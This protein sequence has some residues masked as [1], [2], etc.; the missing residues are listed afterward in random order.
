MTL[1]A[2]AKINIGLRVLHKRD[3]GFHEIETVFHRIALVDEIRFEASEGIGLKVEGSDLPTDQRNLCVRAALALK[4][5]SGVGEGVSIYLKKSIPAGAGLGGGSSDAATTLIGLRRLW[6][7]LIDDA[8]LHRLAMELGSDVPY[9]L[10]R[11]AAYA[12]GRGEL[13]EDLPLEVPY[14]IVV[15]HPRVHVSTQAAYR[16][17]AASRNKANSRYTNTLKRTVLESMQSLDE[18]RRNVGNDFE[19]LVFERYPEV[20]AAKRALLDCGAGFA[21]MSGSGSSVFGFFDM[22]VDDIIISSLRKRNW[23]VFVTPPSFDPYSE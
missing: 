17:L 3:D 22:P 4:A 8:G 14:T 20:V 12:T 15:V 23:S 11:G 7:L 5:A 6:N 19:S 16:D 1:H 18:L 9:F 13:L 21:L 2:H 10:H